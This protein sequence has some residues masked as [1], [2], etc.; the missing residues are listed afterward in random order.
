MTSTAP[1]VRRSSTPGCCATRRCSTRGT[2][3]QI[4]K[5]HYA[6]YT[7]EMVADICGISVDDFHYLAQVGHREQR[8]RAHHRVR[9]CR[10]LDPAHARRPVHPHRGDPAAAARQHGPPGRRHHGAARP[11]EHPGLDRHPDAL[12]HPPRLPRDARGGAAR[13]VGRLPRRHR[14]QGAEGLLGQRRHVCREPAQGVVG[15]GR[16]RRERLVLR[17]PA[18]AVRGARHLP[19]DDGDARRRGRGLLPARPEPGRRL[20]ARPTCSGW[21][22]RT[23]SG[24]SCATST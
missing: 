19:D 15:Q 4:L 21:P 22:C 16:D 14:Q 2:V 20:G 7:P 8:P 18:A 10:R 13:H 6:R 3:F 11:R 12:Q 24:S 9:V 17:L 1:A 23:S 5:R